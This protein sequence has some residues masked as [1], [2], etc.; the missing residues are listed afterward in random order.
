MSE[1]EIVIFE[2]EKERACIGGECL[3]KR[4]RVYKEKRERVCVR[5]CVCLCVSVCLTVYWVPLMVLVSGKARI[6]Q[7]QVLISTKYIFLDRA[8]AA[9]PAARGMCS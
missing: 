8:V 3:H 9:V 7:T 6:W 1:R 2:C 4:E 5:E